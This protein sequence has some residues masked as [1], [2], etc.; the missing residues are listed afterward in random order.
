MHNGSIS[1]FEVI[2]RGLS[3]K[4]HYDAFAAMT[5]RTDSEQFAALYVTHLGKT[6]KKPGGNGAASWEEN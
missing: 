1:N 5:G 3:E 4:M 2:A 6:N